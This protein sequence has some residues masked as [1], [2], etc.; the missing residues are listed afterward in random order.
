MKPP[1]FKYQFWTLLIVI[2]SNIHV[3]EAQWKNEIFSANPEQEFESPKGMRSIRPFQIGLL[4]YTK[5]NEYFQ[6][7]SPGETFFGQRLWAITEIEK[8]NKNQPLT[9]RIGMSI[10]FPFQQQV[11]QKLAA[12]PIIQ[13][14][15]HGKKSSIQAGNIDAHVQHKL[16][17]PVMSYDFALSNPVE[18]GLNWKTNHKNWDF[19]SWLNWR[20]L[21]IVETSQQEIISFGNRANYQLL[22]NKKVQLTLPLYAL[23]YHKG[24]EDLAIPKN[25]QNKLSTGIG[26]QIN[27]PNSRWF[28]ESWKGFSNDFSPQRNQPFRNGDYWLFS[29][30]KQLSNSHRIQFNYFQGT[31]FHSPLGNPLFGSV[32]LNNP[33]KS[34]PLNNLLFARYSYSKTLNSNQSRGKATME[35][36]FEPIFKIPE[37]EFLFSVG[38]YFKYVLGGNISY[39]P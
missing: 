25:I 30:T 17:D 19:N 7:N 5:D 37:N 4:Q 1:I 23:M 9:V 16:P 38:L 13:M 21:A 36:R 15:Y 34:M 6:P 35:F 32:N 22:M 24:G 33:Y 26:F 27:L 8:A 3:V 31:E 39:Q 20:Q 18:Y 2:I 14:E 28:L 29:A 11:S 10:Q 12:Y